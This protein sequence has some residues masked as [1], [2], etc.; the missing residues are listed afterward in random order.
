MEKVW[1]EL[2][3]IEAQAEQIRVDAQTQ[4]KKMTQQAKQDADKL[5]GNSKTYAEEESQ[6]I[7]ADAVAVAN[8]CRTQQLQTN[9][10]EAEKL[11]AQAQKRMDKAVA[12]IVDAVLEE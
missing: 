1:D 7:Y 11:K 5:V 3:R 6:K 2:K 9:A 12:V 8:A 4:A 10:Q